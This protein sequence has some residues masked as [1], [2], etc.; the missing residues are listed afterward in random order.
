MP[1][2]A[3]VRR[4]APLAIKRL[5]KRR[6]D[7]RRA[8]Q[9][10]GPLA[11][12]VPPVDDM[13]DGP[14]SLEEFKRNGEEFLEIYKR[15]CGLEPHERVLD[16]GSGIGRKTLPLTQYL[17]SAARYEGIDVNPFGVTWCREMITPR[18]PAFHFQRIDSHNALYNPTGTVQASGYRFPFDDESFT[19][20]TVQ[21]V[22]THMLP[23]D[24]AQYL[25]EIARVLDSGR[26]LASFFLLNDESRRFIASGASSQPFLR[27]EDG[28]ATTSMETPETAI[29]L[30]EGLVRSFFAKT[31]L[32]IV[33][34]HPGSW[35]GRQ[36]TLS[37]QDLLL[38]VKR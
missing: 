7:R 5:L 13:F 27:E 11:D 22:F 15:V 16:V 31:G 17:S 24:V 2:R 18:F 21:S 25:S 3:L 32:E 1:M 37:Y 6:I 20:V 23:V 28:W 14:G 35:C 12:L 8:L 29:A 9:L 34:Q 19:F 26:C 4:F 36:N 30:D 33:A 38:A 10:F